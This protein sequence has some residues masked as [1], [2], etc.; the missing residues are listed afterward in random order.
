MRHASLLL[1]RRRRPPSRRGRPRRS[2]FSSTSRLLP[3]CREG[4]VSALGVRPPPGHTHARAKGVDSV[5]GS[6]D[7]YGETFLSAVE[8]GWT[9]TF[10][11]SAS[12]SSSG[13]T[14]RK[15]R[16]NVQFA[17]I[18]RRGVGGAGAGTGTGTGAGL[19]KRGMTGAA[20][21]GTGRD[22][23]L[24]SQS[25]GG[26]PAGAVMPDGGLSPC[27]IKVVGVGGG[28]CNAVSR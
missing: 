17:G 16:K 2:S 27:V 10:S 8:R 21:S 24:R 22:V 18:R 26:S 7:D 1:G 11:S 6:D 12:S 13:T 3:P 4:S 15:E 28:G 19:G 25:D 23:S 9:P 14:R 5:S 20:G